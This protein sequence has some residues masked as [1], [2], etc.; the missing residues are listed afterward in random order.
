M[1]TDTHATR[2][3]VQGTLEG[4]G[5]RIIRAH[6]DGEIDFTLDGI[7][8]FARER[9]GKFRAS[10]FLEY[11]PDPHDAQ[12]WAARHR[13]VPYAEAQYIEHADGSVLRLLVELPFEE[14]KHIWAAAHTARALHAAWQNRHQGGADLVATLGSA[15]IALPP[16]GGIAPEDVHTYGAWAWG[17]RYLPPFVLYMF[18]VDLV[19]QQL[20]EHGPLFAMAHAGH[21]INSYGLNIVTTCPSG[22]VAAY[23]QHGYGGGYANPVADL[24]NINATYSRLHVL[25][26]AAGEGPGEVRWLLVYSQFRGIWG[27]L[28]LDK[29][30]QG[31]GSENAFEAS[32]SESAVFQAMADRLD[33]SDIDFGTGGNVSW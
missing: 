15:G 8:G 24:I 9:R 13:D 22:A 3:R 25:W 6:G 28:D 4:I 32:G 2:S 30:R 16:L 12:E 26:G 18:E 11:D 10:F 29:V 31:A 33:L 17:S 21:G 7:D 27:V 14:R 1:T 19:A 5:A 23:V 20:I